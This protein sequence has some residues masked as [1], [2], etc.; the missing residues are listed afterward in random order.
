MYRISAAFCSFFL[1][2]GLAV[3]THAQ[4]R[5]FEAPPTLVPVGSQA[6]SKTRTLLFSAKPPVSNCE[7]STVQ[8]DGR[9]TNVALHYK[10][11]DFSMFNPQTGV[12]DAV[13][14]RSYGGCKSGPIIA[15]SPGD[16]L[17]IK[18]INELSANDPSCWDTPPAG[19]SM[20]PGV[21]C[22][23]TINLHTHGLWVSPVGNSDNVLLNIVPQTTFDYEYNIPPEHP[24]GTFW[25]HAHRH[26]STAVQV[27]S[28]ASGVLVIR[29][30]RPYTPPTP[31]D[32]HPRAGDIDTILQTKAGKIPEQF[33]LFQQI[34]YA[35]FQNLP[36]QDG[37]P[38]QQIYTTTGLFNN[39]LASVQNPP[40]PVQTYSP[41]TCPAAAPGKPVTPGMIENFTLQLDS[42]SIWGTNGRF[43]SVNG[44]VQ[45]T[46]EIKA[47]EIQRW[48]FIHAGIHDTI[49]LQIVPITAA[50]SNKLSSVAPLFTGTRQEQTKQ[51]AAICPGTGQDLLPQ[52]QIAADGLTMTAIHTLTGTNVP[53]SDGA[54]YLQPG[55]RSDVLLAFPTGDAYYCLLDQEAPQG[56]HFN[57]GTGQGGGSG[58]NQP[59]V[60]GI[61][62]VTKGTDIPNPTPNQG[63]GGAYIA[64]YIKTALYDGNPQLPKPIRDGLLAGNLTPWAPFTELPPPTPAPTPE[65]SQPQQAAFTIGG[66]P[67]GFTIN[68]LSYDPGVVNI[69]RQVNTTDDWILSAT[70][71]PH[72]FHIH[73]NPFEVIDV[74]HMLD[75]GTQESIFDPVTHKCKAGGGTDLSN[76]YC[77]MW[78]TFHDTIFVENNYHVHVRTHY[79]RYIG[80]FVIHCHILDHE[81]AGMM[82]NIEIVPDL[83][84]PNGGL[85]MKP[86][87]GTRTAMPMSMTQ[88]QPHPAPMPGMAPMP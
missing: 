23:N 15:I 13:R 82:L 81:D 4:V 69:Q 63:D 41:W 8:V 68:G 17:R 65:A 78:H 38:Y 21:G 48:R 45:P 61:I 49:N 28:G 80:E 20:P 77:S 51:I 53:G 59:Q 11:A 62:H 55:Y 33:F 39:T 35:C 56:E 26:G 19:L 44:V 58:P 37:G 73:V 9:V 83:S 14:L 64:S 42:A 29:G 24:S 88:P 47:G 25:Y 60:L 40:F 31:E 52:L 66:N 46:I 84:Q 3:S 50:G 75:D 34:P 27:A 43:T 67:F 18:L 2:A 87:K 76:Q 22:F 32:P 7:T 71:E 5:A 10:L 79:D 30:D 86:M 6:A 85:G 54:N 72:I 16:T 36:N 1:A 57:S 12:D 70:G 74:I